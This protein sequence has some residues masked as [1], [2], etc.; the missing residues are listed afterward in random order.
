MFQETYR[1][2]KIKIFDV[3][4]GFVE[5]KNISRKNKLG[6]LKVWY[7]TNK[8]SRHATRL[9]VGRFSIN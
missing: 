7:I 9:V 5:I 4:E 1:F 2:Q 8:I 3:F 6:N